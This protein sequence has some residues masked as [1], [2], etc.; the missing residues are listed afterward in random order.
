MGRIDDWKSVTGVPLLNDPFVT[1]IAFI[2][3]P[4][5]FREIVRDSHRPSAF[6]PMLSP[7]DTLA[8]A[9]FS[10]GVRT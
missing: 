7:S 5:D 2:A 8:I 10:S 1:G 3:G 9:L 4:S 6:G